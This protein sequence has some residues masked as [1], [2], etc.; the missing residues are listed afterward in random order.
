MTTKI[1]SETIAASK[2][3]DA[4]NR[5]VKIASDR[6]LFSV[7]D[8]NLVTNWELIGRI[9]RDANL[10]HQFSG[11]VTEELGKSL[12]ISVEP[13]T[14]QIGKQI[15]VGFVQNERLPISRKLI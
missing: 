15:L 2:L 6:H 5:A 11:D 9:A 10:A 13:A 4:V 1:R 7:S 12:G 3:S 8:A 14:F